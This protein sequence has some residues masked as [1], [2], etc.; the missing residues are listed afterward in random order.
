VR[1]VRAIAAFG[2]AHLIGVFSKVYDRSGGRV[3]GRPPPERLPSPEG[4][5]RSPNALFPHAHAPP[6]TIRRDA[7]VRRWP[8]EDVLYQAVQAHWPQVLEDLAEH[9]DLPKFV[10][11]EFEEYLPCGLLSAG[12]LHL[13]CRSCGHSQLVALSCKRCG[14]CSFQPP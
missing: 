7:S 13:V 10:V 14:V 8:E 6:P 3:W 12:C 11:R 2:L 4:K 5:P 1:K 9:G